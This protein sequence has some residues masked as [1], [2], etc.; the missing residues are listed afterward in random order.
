MSFK[1]G[2][3]TSKTPDLEFCEECELKCFTAALEHVSSQTNAYVPRTE[4]GTEWSIAF[5]STMSSLESLRMAISNTPAAENMFEDIYL[6]MKYIRNVLEGNT[7]RTAEIKQE[8]E[9]LASQLKTTNTQLAE[10]EKE[11]QQLEQFTRRN[12]LEIHG[13]PQPYFTEN[14]DDVVVELVSAVGINIS[15]CDIDI[16]YRLS[17]AGTRQPQQQQQLPQPIIVKFVT[18]SLRDEIYNSRKEIQTKSAEKSTALNGARERVHIEENLTVANKKLFHK[19]NK[20]R[21][22]CNWKFIWTLN[23]RIFVRKNVGENA[24]SIDS[25]TDIDRIW[26]PNCHSC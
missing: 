23:G 11:L 17:P 4:S 1:E 22:L 15:T 16:S 20:I 14:T 19:A 5:E 12:H 6:S 3:R 9:I 8:K 10:T 21:K 18:Q 25:L 2:I 24:I 26:P 7:K 13:V